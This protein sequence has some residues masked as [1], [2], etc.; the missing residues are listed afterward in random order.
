[1]TDTDTDDEPTVYIYKLPAAETCASQTG[2]FIRIGETG[3]ALVSTKYGSR[4][5]YCRRHWNEKNA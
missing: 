3:Y 5:V 4:D 2:C 1:M